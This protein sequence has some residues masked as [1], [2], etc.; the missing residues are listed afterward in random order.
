MHEDAFTVYSKKIGA[1]FQQAVWKQF[2]PGLYSSDR[3][4]LFSVLKD[5]LLWK[6]S[7]DSVS[8]FHQ[9]NTVYETALILSVNAAAFLHSN[10]CTMTARFEMFSNTYFFQLF[11]ELFISEQSRSV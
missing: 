6:T 11:Q 7:L 8:T 3:G 4:N 2:I 5:I 9:P 1:M 10:L